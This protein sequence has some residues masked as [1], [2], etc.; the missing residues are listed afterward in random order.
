MEVFPGRVE[1]KA[2]HSATKDCKRGATEELAF[3]VNMCDKMTLRQ[4]YIKTSQT[5]TTVTNMYNVTHFIYITYDIG[6]ILDTF[7][8]K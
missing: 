5:F 4:S 2:N 6:F 3:I 8:S 1:N 7:G